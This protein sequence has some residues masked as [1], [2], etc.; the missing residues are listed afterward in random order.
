MSRSRFLWVV[1]GTLA[2]GSVGAGGAARA[3]EDEL[4]HGIFKLI[5]SP[6]A[7]REI[8]DPIPLRRVLNNPSNYL[9]VYVRVWCRFHREESLETPEY[10][11]FNREKYMNFSAWD[12]DARLWVEEERMNDLPFLFAPKDDRLVYEVAR[13]QK[14]DTILVYGLV[15]TVF[16]GKP[17]IEVIRV[18]R[19]GKSTLNDAVLTHISV[20]DHLAGKQMYKHA[21]DELDRALGYTTTDELT[22]ELWKWKGR[23]QLA[24]QMTT[25]A[26]WSLEQARG[27]RT[28]DAE[29]YLWLAEAQLKTA[30]A[31]GVSRYYWEALSSARKSLWHQGRQSRAYAIVGASWRE[32]TISQMESLGIVTVV[33]KERKES[34]SSRIRPR[35]RSRT[36]TGGVRTEQEQL[37]VARQAITEATKS[38]LRN[39]LLTAER[40]GQKA[41]TLDPTDMDAARWLEETKNAL[42]DFDRKMAEIE[43]RAKKAEREALG[44]GGEGA[45][46]PADG[47]GTPPADGTEGGGETPARPRPR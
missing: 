44:E 42:K 11:P 19:S 41:V 47:E 12:A 3:D 13:L 17:W 9:N 25:E 36:T 29:V 7:R 34:D 28:T 27:Y 14:Y 16:L 20:A 10:T 21:V 23:W 6:E 24:G 26:V 2:V 1:A 40:E 39:G 38:E 5:Y 35:D 45:A 30:M 18:T 4:D 22:G 31:S 15:R 33:R 37:A 46:P 43:E 32:I 8:A